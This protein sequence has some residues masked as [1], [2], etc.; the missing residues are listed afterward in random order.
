MYTLYWEHMAGS[1]VVQAMLREV[2]A[3]Y[4][5]C[6]VDMASNEH[7]S[8]RYL[9]LVPSGCVPAIELPD[10]TTIGETAAIVTLLGEHYPRSALV[11][12]QVGSARAGFL[13][14]LN[15][16]ATAGYLTVSRKCH[17]ERYAS[18]PEAIR[19]VEVT[20]ATNVDSFFDM[21][22]EAVAGNPYFLKSGVS[23]LDLYLSML[24]EWSDDR[25]GLF[26]TRPALE[27]LVRATAQRP[28]YLAAMDTHRLPGSA[29]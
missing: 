5:L 12:V 8:S 9:S 19:Q 16:M 24:T 29:A 14:W 1:I 21:M 17:P 7:R 15:V 18:S 10:G 3:D 11:P 25:D 26:S 22:N 4:Q 27:E 13:F 28:A 2:Q 20:A 23:A 6:H